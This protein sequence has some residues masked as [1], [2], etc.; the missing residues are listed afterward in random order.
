M[1]FSDNDIR[2]LDGF[3]LLYRMKTLLLN[4]NRICR[5]ADNL[6]ESLPS[7]SA[8]IMTGNMMLELGDL[9]PLVTLK[10]LE[11][12]SL[13]RNPVANHQHYRLYVI[14]KIPFLKVLDFRKIKQS[15]RDEA[16]AMFKGKK[17]KQLEKDLGQK[18][19]NLLAGAPG[20]EA[21]SVS[22]SGRTQ[23]EVDAI[24]QAI[25]NARSLEEIERLHEMLQAGQIPGTQ[26]DSTPVPQGGSSIV[27]EDDM[28]IE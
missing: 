24:K 8:L 10:K 20:P 13:V 16:A 5:I 25:G 27:E 26:V 22:T 6:H 21:L 1:D 9:D 28:E 3:P 12:L 23:D 17:G 2:K 7:L 15:E 18:T 4:N 14:Y 19:Q 11:Y